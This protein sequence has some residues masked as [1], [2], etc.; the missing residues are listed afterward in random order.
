MDN[1]IADFH[2]HSCYSHDSLMSPESIVKQ[3]KRVGL[4]CIAITDHGT[5]RGGVEGEKFAEKCGIKIIIGA[6]IKTDRGDLIGLNLNREIGSFCWHD[7]IREIQSQG[8]IV[9]LPHPFHDHLMVE[10]IATFVDFIEVWNSRC[11]PIENSRAEALA[12]T[13]RK[14]RIYGSDAHC[15]SE[16]GLVKVPFNL[17]PFI[18]KEPIGFNYTNPWKIRTSQVVS[19]IRKHEWRQLMH[20]G[21]RFLWKKIT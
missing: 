21:A 8:G 7:V 2:I 9:V 13:L 15:L 10:E 4:T 20:H 5:I 17:D 1:L 3:A 14:K 18:V 11:T 6:E 12:V 16:I 19:Y